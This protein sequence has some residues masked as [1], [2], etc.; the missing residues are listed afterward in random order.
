MYTEYPILD[1]GCKGKPIK[2]PINPT[3][4][5]ILILRLLFTNLIC[6]LISESEVDINLTVLMITP[7]QVNL[8][9]IHTLKRQE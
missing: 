5:R 9:R 4:Y 2:E 8:F 1:R 7:D 3:E 6:T